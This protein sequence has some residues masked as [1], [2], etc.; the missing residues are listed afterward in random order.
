MQRRLERG[1]AADLT[2]EVGGERV[3][4]RPE[5]VGSDNSDQKRPCFRETLLFVIPLLEGS[6]GFP[7]SNVVHLP[8]LAH[9]FE[10][11]GRRKLRD[12]ASK[13][14]PVGTYSAMIRSP[15]MIWG[16]PSDVIR[17]GVRV[18]SEKPRSSAFHQNRSSS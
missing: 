13:S 17:V 8:E 16:P 5:R 7:P 4:P 2:R 3:D 1:T 15:A 18:I 11:R 10:A 12:P 14:P 9:P 6:A